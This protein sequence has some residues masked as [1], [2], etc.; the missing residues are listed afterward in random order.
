MDL[1]EPSSKTNHAADP[2]SMAAS[3]EVAAPKPIFPEDVERTINNALLSDDRD[4]CGTMA[5]VS[6]R[7]YTWT[8]AII[9]RTVVVRRHNSDWTKRI[10]HFLLP[11]AN[12]IHTLALDLPYILGEISTEELS[13]IR[14]LLAASDRV[15]HLAVTW[16]I[17]AQ[18]HRE[19][20]ALQLESL[21]L[22]WDKNHPSSPPSLAHLQHPAALKDLTVYAPPD[23]RN[24]TPFRGIGDLYL[25]NTARCANLAYVTYAADRTPIPTIGSLCEDIPTLRSAMF[26]LVDIPEKFTDTEDDLITEDKEVYPNFSTAYV[27]FSRQVLGEWLA[28]IEGKPSVL[29]HPPP[30]ARAM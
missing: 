28:K 18:L 13:L 27:R 2:L 20:G 8:K 14:A 10:S 29:A 7:F 4:M 12:L 21:Y 25:P 19:C 9:F 23:L 24:L 3:V 1:S 17:W 16:K 22:M 15:R 11:N 26:V 6:S 5:L 30:R